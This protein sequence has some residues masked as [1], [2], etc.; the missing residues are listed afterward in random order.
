[1]GVTPF[2]VTPC[3]P[4]A[5]FL[6]SVSSTF[7][8]AEGWPRSLSSRGRNASTRRHQK[9]S[10]EQIVKSATQPL[11][12][13]FPLNQQAKKGVSVLARVTALDYQG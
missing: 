2:S 11:W 1:M 13:P 4:V 9:D 8:S 7:C 3:Q 12:A 10:T 5:K 6:L